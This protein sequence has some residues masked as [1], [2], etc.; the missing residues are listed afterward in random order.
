[1]KTRLRPALF[2][3]LAL[4]P[5]IAWL[6][7]PLGDRR[8]QVHWNREQLARKEAI[9]AGVPRARGHRPNIVILLA[10]DLGKTDLSLY[11]GMRQKTP[12]IDGLGREGVVFTAG[13]CTSPI[14][15]PSRA[16]LLTGRYQQRSGF[17]LQPMM[18]YPKNRLEYGVYKNFVIPRTGDWVV[19]PL[20]PV[21][22]ADEI[23]KQGLSPAELA[24][25]EILKAS[26]YATAGIGKWHLGYSEALAPQNR[27]FDHWYGCL[28]AFT[29]FAPVSDTNMVESR[30]AYFADKH[31]WA[32][33][34]GGPSAIR[35]NGVLIDEKEYLTFAIA[36]EARAFIRAHRAD[37]FF[38]YVPFTAPHTPFQ[39]PRAY[40]ERFAGEADPN[41]RVYLAM[42]AALDDAVGS[43]LATIKEAGLDE[44]TLILF[45]SDNG[46]AAYTGATDNA[47]LKGGKFTLFE[48]GVNV[49][50]LLR[51]KGK[52]PPGRFEAP[53]LLP[54]FF[55]TALAAAGIP[56]PTDRTYDG[57]DLLPHLTG[58]IAAPPHR[59][60]YW[61]SLHNRAIR[62]DGWKLFIDGSGGKKLAYDLTTDASERASRAAE[63]P[64]V[65]RRLEAEFDAWEKGLMP[66]QWPRVMDYRVRFD[67]GEFSYAL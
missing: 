31:I 60:I 34:R 49:P 53:V 13:Y 54:D 40:V 39:A 21:P 18:R 12:H 28:E 63:H 26:G 4:A 66:P 29:L 37:P 43:I 17:E 30:H 67:D 47:P 51:W 11:G 6:L 23:L 41:R 7:W 52:L 1:M 36:R 2:I 42:I 45:A 65:V 59:A 44:D 8:L 58:R 10:D 38:L 27:G 9:L 33:G 57:V 35:T 24:L 19:A 55:A 25:P 48:G 22:V 32:Q 5:F 14:C 15:A 3:V 16:S 46:G 61:R 50:Y 20:A 64:E 62:M 56:L